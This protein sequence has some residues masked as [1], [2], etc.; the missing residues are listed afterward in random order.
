MDYE[1]LLERSEFT[2]GCDFRSQFITEKS[3]G[4]MSRQKVKQEPWSS[5]ADLL[6]H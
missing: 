1:I 4:K 6:S 3:H 2:S 5:M